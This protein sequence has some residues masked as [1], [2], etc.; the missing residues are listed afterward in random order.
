MRSSGEFTRAVRGGRRAGRRT[1]V[2]HALV[3]GSSAADRPETIG[4]TAVAPARIG[5][6]VSRAVGPAV[7][8]NR[9]KRRLRHIARDWTDQFPAGSL[10]VLRAN[11]PAGG[12][13]WT[14]LRDDA[15][16]ARSRLSRQRTPT[17]GRSSAR[18]RG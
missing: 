14:E 11:P 16:S 1:V 12:A 7:V 2:L 8:R 3:P 10:V 15:E 9:V 18:T 17:G 6:V 4:P 13:T 5:F